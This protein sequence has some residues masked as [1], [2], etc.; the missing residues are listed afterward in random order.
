MLENYL[1][2][3]REEN[4]LCHY[5]SVDKIIQNFLKIDA[6]NKYDNDFLLRL[7]TVKNSACPGSW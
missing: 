2:W 5:L 6:T 4:I 1:L 3:K 7:E